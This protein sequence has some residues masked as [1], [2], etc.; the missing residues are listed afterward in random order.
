MLNRPEVDDL[1]EQPAA[2]ERINLHEMA[3][4]TGD[5]PGIGGVIKQ[6]PEDFLVD[7]VP[8]YA[9]TGEGEHLYMIV[10]KRK[11]LTSDIAR[12]LA[13]HFGVRREAV[14]YAGLKDKHAITR[15]AITIQG[16][17]P[18][19][20]PKF[21]DD[22]IKI[23]SAELHRNKI[24]RGHLA[25]N[26]FVIK[27]REVEITKVL[28]AK[29]AM[30]ALI[31][32]GVPNYLGEQRFGYRQ[33][34]HVLGRHLLQRDYQ[35]F[36]DRLLG[37]PIPNEAQH[38]QDAR[39]AYDAGDY[40]KAL[41]TW[42]TVHRFERQAVGP[43]S[44]GSSPSQAVKAIDRQ[45]LTLLVSAFQ[46]EVFN[47]VLDQRLRAG[48]FTTMRIGDIA[49]KHQSR[50][51]FTVEDPAE[52][53][54]R[55]DAQEI[56]PT[57]PMWG[58]KMLIPS[59]QTLSEEQA[60][61]DVTGVSVNQIADAGPFAPEGSRRSLRMLV[62]DADVSAGSDEHGPYIRLAFELA[63]GCFA[64]TVLREIMKASAG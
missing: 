37:D 2:I 12:L 7:E 1:S 50:G 43:I 45:Q 24:K 40:E 31:Q 14:G 59:G 13:K 39:A 27:V 57:G 28:Q 19:L 17:D 49:F 15:Q 5:Q 33:N 48:Q 64:T 42:P 23:L 9:P 52:D 18:S 46:S 41:N 51:M 3:Y 25:A 32:S 47:R 8:L 16:A 44:R 21:E 53:Q 22:Y 56:S 30:D 20:A 38:A 11:R 26:R 58:P 34:N 6:R 62:R 61:L 4:L 55:C 35:S 29:R 54:P 63:R 60:A 36:C 10:E